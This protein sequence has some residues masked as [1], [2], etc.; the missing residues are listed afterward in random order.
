[1]RREN[2]RFVVEG[3]WL[4]NLLGSVNFSD[5]ESLQYLHRVLYSSGVYDLLR[6]KGIKEGDIVSIYD[7]EFEYVN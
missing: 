2:D 5:Y 6:E 1:M 3:E 4:L 7:I